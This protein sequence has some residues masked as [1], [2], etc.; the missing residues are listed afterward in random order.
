MLERYG[1]G[2]TGTVA[3]LQMTARFSFL[4]FFLAYAGGGLAVLCG[5]TLRPIERHG[6]D[7]GL[8]FAADFVA[9]PLDGNTAHIALDL[10]FAILNIAAPVLHAISLVPSF[11][12]AAQ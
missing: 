1:T 4:F 5:P 12:R 7:F 10:P 11:R 8:A 6:R 3:A 2:K 9:P